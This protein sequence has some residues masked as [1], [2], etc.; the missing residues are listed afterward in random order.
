ME[1]E[2]LEKFD[3]LIHKV[4]SFKASKIATLL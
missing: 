2:L 3:K 4:L 1:N